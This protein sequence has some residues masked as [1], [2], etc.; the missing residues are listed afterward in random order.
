MKGWAL[1]RDIGCRCTA[2]A[3]GDVKGETGGG[4]ENDCQEG[5][6][7]REMH[8]NRCNAERELREKSNREEIE[9]KRPSI[10]L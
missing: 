9:C 2:N 7:R 3:C 8:L 4:E 1:P 5:R 6:K 10:V